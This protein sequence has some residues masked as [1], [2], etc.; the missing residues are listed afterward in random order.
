MNAVGPSATA[1]QR[2]RAEGQFTEPAQR[3]NRLEQL[4]TADLGRNIVHPHPEAVLDPL[5]I[6]RG[7][8]RGPCCQGMPNLAV[9]VPQHDGILHA[10]IELD[11][12]K[13]F[14]IDVEQRRPIEADHQTGLVDMLAG[15]CRQQRSQARGDLLAIGSTERSGVF[16]PRPGGPSRSSRRGGTKSKIRRQRRRTGV[17]TLEA[18]SSHAR[19]RSMAIG[20]RRPGRFGKQKLRHHSSGQSVRDVRTLL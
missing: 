10:R 8:D 14:E 15:E 12:R 9:A 1:L 4:T 18:R 3:I 2:E 20:H 6:G 7:V 19:G 17:D 5:E 13:E 16:A 11:G